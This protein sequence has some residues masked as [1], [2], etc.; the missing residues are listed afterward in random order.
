[1][2]QELQ[3]TM[4]EIDRERIGFSL[5]RSE[6][7]SRIAYLEALIQAKDR[8]L[9]DY[10]RRISVL[11]HA[12]RSR[13]PSWKATPVTETVDSDALAERL[14]L[15][16]NRPRVKSC[17]EI[18][19]R[20]LGEVLHEEVHK[21]EL[22]KQPH[23]AYSAPCALTSISSIAT[24][25]DFMFVGSED[26]LINVLHESNN[27]DAPVSCLMLRGHIGAVTGLH[28]LEG[29]Q[30]D[31][32]HF[33]VLSIGVD[34]TVRFW[35][36]PDLSKYDQF[37]SAEKIPCAVYPAHS[38]AAGGIAVRG[39]EVATAGADGLVCFWRLTEKALLKENSISLPG[40]QVAALTWTDGSLAVGCKS[41]KV[42]FVNAEKVLG[43]L[44]GSGSLITAMTN[45]SDGLW[46]AF[47]DGSC[48]LIDH[49]LTSWS[50]TVVHSPGRAVWAAMVVSDGGLVTASDDGTLKFW[51]A[52]DAIDL[53]SEP[54]SCIVGGEG[55]LC[56]GTDDGV[57]IKVVYK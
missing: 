18:L 9:Q 35:I 36:L 30:S 16:S 50:R 2:I 5:E 6:L 42:Y 1:M 23:V 32:D 57:L 14:Y 41:S 11:E 54:L 10:S 27:R 12:V 40:E 46:V 20:Y 3:Q 43:Q 15:L 17:K 31:A 47:T 53:R 48:R 45:S 26:G 49:G 37:E 4:R 25:G 29:P 52:V 33:R 44:D 38:D 22:T 39:S 34:G 13:D 51:F 19:N 8:A 28:V 21:P 24:L 55:G 7:E 56:V